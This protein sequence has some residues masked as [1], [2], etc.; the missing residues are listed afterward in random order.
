[1]VRLVRPLREF[2]DGTDEDKVTELLRTLLVAPA[3]SVQAAANDY[4]E[5]LRQAG[6]ASV[7]ALENLVVSD[8]VALG[9]VPGHAGM[10]LS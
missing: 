5:Q 8:L 10:V 9:I 3:L 2:A 7:Q 4:A 6:F 1:M